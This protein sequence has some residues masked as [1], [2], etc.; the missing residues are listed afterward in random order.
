MCLYVFVHLSDDWP[1][2]KSA[3]PHAQPLKCSRGICQSGGDTDILVNLVNKVCPFKVVWLSLLKKHS[4][5][6]KWINEG[7]NVADMGINSYWPKAKHSFALLWSRQ[8]QL[9]ND[10]Y[11]KPI[12]YDWRLLVTDMKSCSVATLIRPPSLATTEDW[13]N[14][15]HFLCVRLCFFCLCELCTVKEVGVCVHGWDLRVCMCVDALHGGGDAVRLKP[16][17]WLTVNTP[18]RAH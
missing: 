1:A 10:S 8:I 18:L 11:I 7:K 15:V 12:M 4:L 5:Y 17:L 3:D 16:W 9:S 13:I 2:K 14:V 6:F